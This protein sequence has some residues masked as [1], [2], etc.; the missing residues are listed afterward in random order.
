MYFLCNVMLL[1]CYYCKNHNPVPW[2]VLWSKIPSVPF[3]PATFYLTPPA[4]LGTKEYL[5]LAFF[6]KNNF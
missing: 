6:S 4:Q 2:T 1:L 3:L 5:I